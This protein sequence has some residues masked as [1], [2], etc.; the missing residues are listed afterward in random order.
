M[1]PWRDRAMEERRALNPALV[2]QVIRAGVAGHE[3][4]VGS[5]LPYALAFPLVA[6]V[7]HSDT[8]VALP[9]TVRTSL[10]VWIREHPL[11]HH[12]LGPRTATIAPL[13]R[14]GVILGLRTGVLQLQQAALISPARSPRPA[15]NRSELDELVRSAHRVGRWF[16]KVGSPS[17]VLTLLGIRI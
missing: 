12:Q 14:E 1:L 11:L 6:A 9:R 8:R 16:A 10:P 4:E 2:T 15:S 17:T 3:Q 7:L 5:G 13:V